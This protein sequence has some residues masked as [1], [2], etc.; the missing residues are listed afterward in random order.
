MLNHNMYIYYTYY[1]HILQLKSFSS[2]APSSKNLNLF[3]LSQ[4]SR[5]GLPNRSVLGDA[6]FDSMTRRRLHGRL[7]MWAINPLRAR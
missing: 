5:N 7:T 6:I 1:D 4:K 2:I 3:S